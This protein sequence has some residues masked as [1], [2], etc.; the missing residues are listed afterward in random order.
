MLSYP[1]LHALQYKGADPAGYKTPAHK[2]SDLIVR[3]ANPNCTNTFAG[4]QGHCCSEAC[5]LELM[6]IEEN[7]YHESFR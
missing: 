2:R 1:E 6:E 3:C 5:R 4:T 7:D